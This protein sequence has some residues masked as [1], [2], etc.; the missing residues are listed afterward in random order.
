MAASRP[1]ARSAGAC[2]II[3]EQF[4]E[5]IRNASVKAVLIVLLDFAMLFVAAALYLRRTR[6]KPGKVPVSVNYH[7]TRRCNYS[8]G[9]HSILDS[10]PLC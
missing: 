1:K 4:D 8:C 3:F 2:S 5:Y 6:T 7:I 9:M 10:S